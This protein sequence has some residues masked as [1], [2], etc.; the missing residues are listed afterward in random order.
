MSNTDPPSIDAKLQN[1]TDI[2]Y[3]I[4]G[5]NRHSAVKPCE[6]LKKSLR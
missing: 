4:L 6:W 2:G 1:L 5:P 3:R